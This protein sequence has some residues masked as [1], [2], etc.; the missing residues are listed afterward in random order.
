MPKL[1]QQTFFTP[2]ITTKDTGAQTVLLAELLPWQSTC[3]PLC[4]CS[5]DGWIETDT[6]WT[7]KW[8]VQIK[9]VLVYQASF[10]HSWQACQ[11]TLHLYYGAIWKINTVKQSL[12]V[13][14]AGM[15]NT[16]IALLTHK[17]CF[18]SLCQKGK[19]KHTDGR[20]VPFLLLDLHVNP[21]IY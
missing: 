5:G 1:T 3:N 11:W 19:A 4:W 8:N 17:L 16:M 15:S 12:R 6:E 20:K 10:N 13:T 7:G 18:V 9:H 21:T 14:A 2:N